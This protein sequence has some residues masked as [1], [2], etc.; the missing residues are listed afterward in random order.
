MAVPFGPGVAVLVAVG[1]TGTVGVCSP[2][3]VVVRMGVLIDSVSS[4][5]PTANS[6]IALTNKASEQS[7]FVFT[8]APPSAL[9]HRRHGK[10]KRNCRGV[11]T[12]RRYVC[13]A[14]R[15]SRALRHARSGPVTAALSRVGGASALR[16][17]HPAVE[18]Q[19]E[20][21]QVAR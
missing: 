19:P 9:R 12:V 14:A 1:K 2:D 18:Q 21:G 16:D 6:S 5:Q 8:D 11:S 4:P 10:V 20:D 13:Q 7:C 15:S 17:M 3:A